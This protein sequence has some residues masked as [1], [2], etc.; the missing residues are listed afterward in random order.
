MFLQVGDEFVVRTQLNFLPELGT[1]V[2]AD[3]GRIDKKESTV[4][5]DDRITKEHRIKVDIRPAEVEEPGDFIQHRYH[6]RTCLLFLQL[7]TH[8]PELFRVASA[9]VLYIERIDSVLRT[10]RSCRAPDRI[11]KIIVVREIDPSETL[12]IG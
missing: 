3:L 4:G 6:E 11:D 2:L 8:V 7:L 12:G 1:H 9:G 5:T 10:V